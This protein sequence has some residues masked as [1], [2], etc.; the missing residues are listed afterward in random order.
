MFSQRASLF[1]RIKFRVRFGKL[2]ICL[3]QPC[4][5]LLFA[6]VV[7]VFLFEADHSAH[8]YHD[9]DYTIHS[10]RLHDNGSS[11]QSPS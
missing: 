5:Q 7:P 4:K 6:F 10:V 11:F 9:R 8:R 3:L 2:G 1:V